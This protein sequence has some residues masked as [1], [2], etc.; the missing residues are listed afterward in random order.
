MD[1]KE[2][3]TEGAARQSS[4]KESGGEKGGHNESSHEIQTDGEKV[5][6]EK[7]GTPVIYSI[8]NG[9]C[10]K[11]VCL[12]SG[13]WCEGYCT[14]KDHENHSATEANYKIYKKAIGE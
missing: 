4:T 11:S 9:R 6:Y 5:V 13:C 10:W 14:E 7:D 12:F 8:K 3:S 2:I 1:P